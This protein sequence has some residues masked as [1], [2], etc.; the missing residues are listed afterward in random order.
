MTLRI[1]PE[2]DRSH[3]KRQ[4]ESPRAIRG[5]ACDALRV[6]GTDDGTERSPGDV[7]QQSATS[8]IPVRALELGQ[9]RDRMRRERSKYECFRM[10]VGVADDAALFQLGSLT[11]RD[12]ELCQANAGT[13]LS[14]MAYLPWCSPAGSDRVLHA[15]CP[16]IS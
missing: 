16:T 15:W 11:V 2:V 13:S 10:A 8:N 9:Y 4:E 14:G 3:F 12:S 7:A 6:A 5:I 1:F